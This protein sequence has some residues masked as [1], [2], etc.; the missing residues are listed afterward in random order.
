MS[1]D[2]FI[3]ILFDI[4]DRALQDGNYEIR[5]ISTC[6][7]NTEYVSDVITGRVDLNSLRFG[8]PL[9]TDGF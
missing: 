6:T 3:I 7:N 5:V 8:T 2:R 1:L 9:P 4:A